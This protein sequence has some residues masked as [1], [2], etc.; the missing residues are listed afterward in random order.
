[1]NLDINHLVRSGAIAL[2]GVPL[3]L[4]ASGL[5]NTTSTIAQRTSERALREDDADLVYR[6]YGDKLAKACIA[7]AVSKPDNKLEREAKNT[8]DEV[9]GGEVDYRLVC[10]TFVF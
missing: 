10:K 1:M 2:V 4:S 5:I 9:M 8:I 6:D 3:A 7:W